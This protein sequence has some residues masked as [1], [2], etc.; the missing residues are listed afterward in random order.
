MSLAC[1]WVFVAPSP[2][3]WR[4]WTSEAS[5]SLE[6]TLCSAVLV[7]PFKV[8]STPNTQSGD[9]DGVFQIVIKKLKRYHSGIMGCW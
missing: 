6:H 2:R 1:Q 5:L 8:L 9:T 7:A 4:R 3:L